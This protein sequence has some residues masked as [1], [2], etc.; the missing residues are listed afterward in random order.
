MKGAEDASPFVVWGRMHL[1]MGEYEEARKQLQEAVTRDRESTSGHNQLGILCMRQEEY[2]KAAEHFRNALRFDP[3]NLTVKSNLAEAYLKAE[4][5]DKAEAEYKA[6]LGVTANHV[7]SEIGLG[8]VYIAMADTKKD[9]E[10]YEEAICHL[11]QAIAVGKANPASASKRMEKKEWAPVYYSLGYA[12][13]K[14]YGASKLLADEAR[15]RRARED[16][17]LAV[18]ADTEYHK[19]ERA[20][21]KIRER[22]HLRER[23]LERVAPWVILGTAAFVFLVAQVS[24][25]AKG[26]FH[27]PAY[28]LPVTFGSLILMIAGFYLPKL[29]KL[30]VAGIELEKSAVDQIASLSGLEISK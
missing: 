2:K 12:E 18:K 5:P 24:F 9:D 17:D 8:Q 16:F 14:L 7:E 20:L 4:F 27:S 30:K 26:Q 23:L 13:V 3:N 29:L 10:L 6:I 25:L 1:S 11:Q 19:A 28:Y 22:T 15:L 21:K